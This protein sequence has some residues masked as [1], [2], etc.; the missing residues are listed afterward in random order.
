MKE[1]WTRQA[2][3][4]YLTL[5][6]D[7]DL[8]SSHTVLAHCTPYDGENLCQVKFIPVTNEEDMDRT[9]PFITFD[10]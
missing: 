3:L 9:S 8:G 7:I 10:L 5:K 1:L 6:C 2:V 4:S